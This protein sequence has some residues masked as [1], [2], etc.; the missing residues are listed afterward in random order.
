MLQ[1]RSARRH[2][3]ANPPGCADALGSKARDVLMRKWHIG[4]M[5]AARHAFGKTRPT[6]LRR[7]LAVGMVFLPLGVTA[8]PARYEI[9]PE[10][11]TVGFL[12]SHI[13]FARVLGLFT[14]VEGSYVFDEET[15]ELS[16][17]SVVVATASVSTAHEERDDHLRSDDFLDARSFQT[18]TFTAA[19]AERSGERN[20][21]IPGE[22]ELRGQRRPLTLHA[23]WNKSGEYPIGRG[24]YAMG[25][26]ARA[27]LSRSDFGIT[28]A[29]DN[30][31]V[32]D[33]VDII[34]ELEARRQ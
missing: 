19:A 25:V 7:R 16:D 30:G 28:Y 27:T 26:S 9:D 17:V 5:T 24:V 3:R 8:E 6:S 21:A 23:T 12:V 31:W 33:Q 18:M 14:N 10:H 34:I 32:G 20:F 15:G 29:L 22:L 4:P 13:G 11:V 1:D 2:A